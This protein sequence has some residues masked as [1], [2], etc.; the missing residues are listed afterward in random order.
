MSAACNESHAEPI[1]VSHGTLQL[2]G[3]SN[4][5]H[6]SDTWTASV[7]LCLLCVV[8]VKVTVMR[9][10]AEPTGGNTPDAGVTVNALPPPGRNAAVNG[11][12][13]LEATLTVT[14]Y[15][16]ARA[17]STSCQRKATRRDHQSTHT[18]LVVLVRRKPTAEV[19][20]NSVASV[21]MT[22]ST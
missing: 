16:L 7:A 14:V 8:G 21:T 17:G 3:L 1:G 13:L 11:S 18:N 5:T 9:A 12:G 19:V 6:R 22:S 4:K 15:D 10:P 2:V 20:P